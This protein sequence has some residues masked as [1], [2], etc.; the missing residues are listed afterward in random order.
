MRGI[1]LA[2]H[3][4]ETIFIPHQKSNGKASVSNVES[5][6]GGQ[7]SA[8]LSNSRIT[9]GWCPSSDSIIDYFAPYGQDSGNGE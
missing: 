2:E 8:P 3:Q 9:L 5:T 4:E 1:M 6:N 7:V